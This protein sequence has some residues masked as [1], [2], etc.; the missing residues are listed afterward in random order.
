[1]S[2][3]D[4]SVLRN[5][6]YGT[7]PPF[8]SDETGLHGDAEFP[9]AVYHADVTNNFVSWHWHEELE[10]GFA[11]EVFLSSKIVTLSPKIKPYVSAKG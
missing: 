5:E 6:D 1:M 3:L 4:Y 9:I 8:K 7:N 11:V 2:I 10:F